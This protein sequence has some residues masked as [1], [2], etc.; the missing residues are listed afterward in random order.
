MLARL[1]QT[2]WVWGFFFWRRNENEIL[3]GNSQSL[4]ETMVRV[5]LFE[6]YKWAVCDTCRYSFFGKI[7]WRN[8]SRNSV[9]WASIQ[10][11]LRDFG[12]A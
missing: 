7:P 5:E 11:L 2:V 10:H 9:T 1:L 8:I 4:F 3:F 12:L 6:G